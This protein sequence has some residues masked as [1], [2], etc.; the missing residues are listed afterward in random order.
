MQT[1]MSALIRA[2]LTE[3]YELAAAVE[4][5]PRLLPHYRYVRVFDRGR[6]RRLVEMAARRDRIPVWWMAIQE[7]HPDVPEITYR[8]VRGITRGMRVGWGFAVQPD[9]VLVTVRH[10]LDLGWPLVGPLV[11]DR[12]IGPRFVDVIAERTVR[13]I[14]ALAEE[15]QE[16]RR[17]RAL[18]SPGRPSHAEPRHGQ[19]S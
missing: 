1:Q 6:G 9:G 19:E 16:G 15:R 3:V 18:A 7:C 12:I 17:R 5:W 8:H 2:P 10:D 4:D 13:R 11:A 14:K